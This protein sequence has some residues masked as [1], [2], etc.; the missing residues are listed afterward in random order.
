MELLLLLL[1]VGQVGVA[2]IV[3]TCLAINEIE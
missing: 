2:V 3:L 1:F